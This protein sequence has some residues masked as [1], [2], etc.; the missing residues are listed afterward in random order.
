MIVMLSDGISEAEYPTS[1]ASSSGIRSLRRQ[2][3]RSLPE[4]A[5]IF[6]AVSAGM[7]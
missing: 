1:A 5:G 4:G 2:Q 3:P 6:T 7:T